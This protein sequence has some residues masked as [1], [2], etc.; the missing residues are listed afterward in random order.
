M[1]LLLQTTASLRDLREER[2]VVDR[3]ALLLAFDYAHR[4]GLLVAVEGV[5]DYLRV[6]L[7]CAA[8][9]S[10]LVRDGATA[11]F[12]CLVLAEEVNPLKLVSVSQPDHFGGASCLVSD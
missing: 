2:D 9:R 8:D 1:V 4:D 7:D 12:A 3:L 6:A 11:D 5:E 10:E